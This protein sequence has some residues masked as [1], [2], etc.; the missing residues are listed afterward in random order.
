MRKSQI[1][2]M[3][4]LTI[5]ILLITGCS[6]TTQEI[7]KESVQTQ[8]DNKLKEIGDL[9][10]FLS[11]CELKD[12]GNEIA[13]TCDVRE[14][15]QCFGFVVE[16]KESCFYVQKE[17]VKMC[18]KVPAEGE[19]QGIPDN[20]S[21]CS[22][23]AYP[24]MGSLILKPE[25]LVLV[26]GCSFSPNYPGNPYIMLTREEAERKE[27]NCEICEIGKDICYLN[28]AMRENNG[29]FC[30][31]IDSKGGRITCIME[32][33]RKEEDLQSCINV[34]KQV[35]E[36]TFG[37]NVWFAVKEKS[38]GI[39]KQIKEDSLSETLLNQRLCAGK[40]WKEIIGLPY[41][42]ESCLVKS[43]VASKEECEDMYEE[44]ERLSNEL[45]QATGTT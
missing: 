24:K 36:D 38:F 26:K 28:K 29:E 35:E 4:L 30:S 27:T 37:C 6:R 1:N 31:K 39:C 25:S 8:L 43:T 23:Y 3:V 5:L 7:T 32:I 22:F 17:G 42:R 44:I 9:K 16:G 11:F 34:V 12:E 15:T 40:F 20:N 45:E 19:G 13:V 18:S 10:N 33:G 14:R 41:A 2:E 21:S